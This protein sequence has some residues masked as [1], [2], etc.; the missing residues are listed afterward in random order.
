MKPTY[1]TITAALLFLSLCISSAMAHGTSKNVRLHINPKWSECSLQI[2]PSLTQ[3]AWHEF[4]EEAGLVAYFRSMNDARPIGVGNYELSLHQWQTAFDDTKSAWNDTFVHP[5]SAHWL[6]EGDRLAFPG[7]T[8]RTGLT[9]AIDADIYWTKNP[10]ANYGFA[11][12]Q[13]QYMFYHSDVHHWTA[14]ARLNAVSLYGPEDMDLTVYGMEVLASNTYAV[15]SDWVVISPYAGV[16]AYVSTSHEKTAAVALTDEQ[17]A[18]MRG[19]VGAVT[20]LSMAR[21]AVEY[22]IA[23]VNS[24]SFKIG[25]GF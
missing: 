25:V 13:V 4:T 6:K 19:S 14:S 8:F 23:R 20:Q 2:D 7:F 21:V 9:D 1:R 5:D 16:S 3:Q 22:T 12:A 11:G 10:N 17:I 24:L 18:G 15:Y